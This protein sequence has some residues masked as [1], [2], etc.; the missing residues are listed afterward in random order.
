LA[1]LRERQK[2]ER[3]NQIIESARELFQE[4]GYSKTNMDAIADQAL[5]GVA[6]IYTYF[7]NKEGVVSALTEKDAKILLTEVDKFL[8]NLPDEPIEAV[9]KLLNLYGKFADS[10]SYTLVMDLVGK[11]RKDGILNKTIGKIRIRQIEQVKQVLNEH[12]NSGKLSS[13]LDV[14]V[15]ALV[16]L[17]LHDR[18]MHRITNFPQNVANDDTLK[19]TIEVLFGS[20]IDS[21]FDKTE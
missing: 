21:A 10:V 11:L 1:S 19:K 7:D 17:D 20:W 13:Q 12:V 14:D 15:A 5:V 8:K 3:R 6:T 18:H 16:I 9:Y 2:K 4:S